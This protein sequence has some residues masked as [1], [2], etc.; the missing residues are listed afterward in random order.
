MSGAGH[1]K[2]TG[3]RRGVYGILVGKSEGMTPLGRLRLTYGRV[4][5]KWILK[6]CDGGHGLD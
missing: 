1:V 3:D 6:K 5:L 4:I 2:R